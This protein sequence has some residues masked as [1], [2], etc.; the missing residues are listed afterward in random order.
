MKIEMNTIRKSFGSNDVLKD[1]TFSVQ[2]GEICALLGENGA[3]KS[4]LMNILGGV[5]RMDSGSILIDDKEVQFETPVDSLE[6][7]I[8]F[9]HQELNLI[10]DL[11]VYENMFLGREIKRKRG[12]LDLEQM[13][14]KTVEIFERMNVKLDP[15]T[16]VR[17]LDA[18]YK[19]IVEICRAM[20]MNA[21]II[22]MD[23]PTTSL[24]ETEIERVFAMMRTLQENN[25][26]IIFISH[27]LNEVKEICNRY[28]VLRDGILVSTGNVSDVT[29]KDLASYMVGFDVRTESLRRNN[30]QEK[31]KEVL[32]VERL[33]DN[34]H[35]KDIHFS[36]HAGEIVGITGLLGDGRS[37][38]FQAIFGANSYESG[39]IF[40]E[41]KEV[42]I[43]DTYHAI[44]EGIAYLPRNRKEN[45][46]IKD[47]NII[48]NASIVTWPM[49]SN[50]GIINTTRH[51]Q[52]FNE[53]QEALRIKM[54]KMTDNI[55]SLSGG[56]QQKVVLS[57]W[58]AANPKVLILDNPTQ[59]VDVGAK[60][61]IYDIILKLAEENI[62]II[63]LSSE[64]QEIIRVCD[65]A[66]VMYHGVIKGEVRDEMM[67]EQIIMSLATGGELG[68]EKGVY[69]Q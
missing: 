40:L 27:K 34:C 10:N 31:D 3:G 26:G 19:Q 20:M 36:I 37:E 41:G 62:A 42:T 48:E 23:E 12:I 18:S 58:L 45:A 67:N 32:R 57:K 68:E 8:A 11:P 33:T 21:S 5:V 24:T 64:A 46:I 25:V 29:N 15:N 39:K 9:I 54:D 52:L 13:Y 66:L 61:D 50:R 30:I 63:V 60:E 14:D 49:F 55:T 16:M 65:R 17:D 4:T 22:I 28:I 35:F 2:G 59:G 43:K 53:Q 69:Q 1:V 44:Q 7:G 56:N 6:A 51:E 38:L 47:M